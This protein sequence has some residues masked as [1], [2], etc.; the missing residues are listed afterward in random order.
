MQAP[1]TRTNLTRTIAVLAGPLILQ[2]LSYALLGVTDT[3]FVSR[4]STEAVGAVG[5]AGV[6]FFSLMLLFRST[7]AS[8]VV[9]V[10]RAHGA[11][12]DAGIGAAV[13]RLL[14]MIVL[15]SVFALA[16]PWVFTFLFSYVAPGDSPVVLGL[17]TRYL[18][19]R[20]LEVPLAMFSAVVWGFLVGRGDSRTP[21]FLAWTQVLTNIL[22]DWLLVP[23]N[24]G[25]PAWGRRRRSR[26]HS[27]SQRC[28]RPPERLDFVAT[29]LTRAFRDAAGASGRIRRAA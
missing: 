4:I 26:R 20:A 21:M 29:R 2:N 25:F 27:F 3:F 16:L 24:L 6:L 8:S 11:G 5:L 19:I 10:G 28:R 7:A 9:F 18:Q 23:G 14:N 12:D 22:L 13:W 1:S 15:L 17:G